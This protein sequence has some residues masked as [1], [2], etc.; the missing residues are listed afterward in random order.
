M[1]IMLRIRLCTFSGAL[2]HR[3]YQSQKYER[4]RML[5]ISNVLVIRYRYIVVAR[6]WTEKWKE[7][8]S[9]E[10]STD[11]SWHIWWQHVW[12]WCVYVYMYMW[13]FAELK[14]RVNR[15]HHSVVRNKFSSVP[16]LDWLID[17]QSVS[18]ASLELCAYCW[19]SIPFVMP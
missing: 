7:N 2:C 6:T 8:E 4:K 9:D 10:I 11:W 5:Y 17:W 3:H 15:V 14:F 12:V 16:L 1:E 13:A 18:I 19:G